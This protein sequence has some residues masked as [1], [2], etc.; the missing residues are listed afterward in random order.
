MKVIC[1]VTDYA[2]SYQVEEFGFLVYDVMVLKD[3]TLSDVI[4]LHERARDMGNGDGEIPK[5]GQGKN[6]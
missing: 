5:A 6:L 4:D 1:K 3:L 2:T